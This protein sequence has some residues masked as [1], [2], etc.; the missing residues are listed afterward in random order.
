MTVE[1][2]FLAPLPFASPSLGK[3]GFTIR[4]PGRSFAGPSYVSRNRIIRDISVARSSIIVTSRTCGSPNM[5]ALSRMA[6][7]WAALIK[8]SSGS[9]ASHAKLA[10]QPGMIKPSDPGVS[11]NDR[12]CPPAPTVRYSGAW[13]AIS[14]KSCGDPIIT[15]TSRSCQDNFTSYVGN[16]VKRQQIDDTIVSDRRGSRCRRRR[17]ASS[18]NR[19]PTALTRGPRGLADITVL[20]VLPS[21]RRGDYRPTRKPGQAPLTVKVS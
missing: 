8:C 21:A 2:D 15:V 9:I 16:S 20:P 13:H 14:N 10:A 11:R 18:S 5:P 1:G 6:F 19:A 3:A 12:H 4:L 7:R 17:P